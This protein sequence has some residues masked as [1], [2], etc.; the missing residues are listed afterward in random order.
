[1]ITELMHPFNKTMVIILSQ[2]LMPD[3]HINQPLNLKIHHLKAAQAPTL[4]SKSM[5]KEMML[6][7]QENSS[8]TLRAISSVMEDTRELLLQDSLLIQMI[9]S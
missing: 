5:P 8:S 9:S 4:M 7:T 2:K 3:H 6:I 1:M